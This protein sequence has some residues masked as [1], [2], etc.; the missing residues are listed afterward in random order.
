MLGTV[1]LGSIG[2]LSGRNVRLAE[3]V[4]TPA[5]IPLPYTAD[6]GNLSVEITIEALNCSGIAQSF[7]STFSYG[8]F[9]MSKI[10]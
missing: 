1:S 9:P 10:Q 8:T 3:D 5:G 6:G 4:L 2:G 7:S